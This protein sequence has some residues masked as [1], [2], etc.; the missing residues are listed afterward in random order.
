MT[1]E[2]QA[3]WRTERAR[4]VG[5]LARRFGDLDL[6]EEATQEALAAL[7]AQQAQG[8][9]PPERPGAWLSTVAFRRAVAIVRRRRLVTESLPSDDAELDGVGPPT[10]P[11][12][13]VQ[14][15]LLAL[16][17]GCCHPAL[18]VEAQVAL[19][20]RHVCGLSVDQIARAFLVPE[21][22]MAKRLVRARHKIRAAGITLGVPDR[23]HLAERTDAVRAVVYLLFNEGWFGSVA[24][25]VDTELCDEALWLCEQLRAVDDEDPETLGLLALMLVQDSRRSTRTDRVGVLVP[26]ADQ[27][28]SSWDFDA[29]DRARALL[30]AAQDGTIGRY[31]LEAAIAL[32]HVSNESPDWTSIADLYRLLVDLTGSP[33]A[34]LNRAM[35]VGRADGPRAGLALL[36]PLLDHPHLSSTSSLHAAHAD[37]L[38]ALGDTSGAGRSWTTALRVA[39]TE[40]ERMAI[41]RH[42]ESLGAPES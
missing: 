3:T 9:A 39:R 13:P 29:I 14:D 34:Q 42:L 15:D 31:R 20:L 10:G 38:A 24:A 6:A 30:G 22:T 32:L 18:A 21:P 7:A 1:P 16:L 33:T 17:F 4:V 11:P 41:R 8:T 19:T 2:E 26:F 40:G 12:S 23:P 37:L 27:D 5:W 36:A 25:S 35:A 28:R